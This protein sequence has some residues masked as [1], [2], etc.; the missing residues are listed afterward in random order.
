MEH[1]RNFSGQIRLSYLRGF[2]SNGFQ[3]SFFFRQKVM[4]VPFD[5]GIE[6][7]VKYLEPADK[8]GKKKS[9]KREGGIK[10]PVN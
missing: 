9:S 5:P 3:H 6:Q 7:T 10:T 1:T 4:L 2:S 8:T